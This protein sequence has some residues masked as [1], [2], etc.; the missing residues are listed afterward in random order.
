MRWQRKDIWGQGDSVSWPWLVWARPLSST[1]L[2]LLTVLHKTVWGA[3]GGLT[4]SKELK[5]L[6][7]CAAD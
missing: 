7:A 6:F 2:A 5:D 1:V 4:L 3:G